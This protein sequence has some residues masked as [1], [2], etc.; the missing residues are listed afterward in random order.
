MRTYYNICKMFG[1]LVNRH[2][3]ER[4]ARSRL[5]SN[6]SFPRNINASANQNTNN[7]RENQNKNFGSEGNFMN[8]SITKISEEYTSP[9]V[10][11]IDISSGSGL[12]WGYVGDGS[13]SYSVI[14]VTEMCIL[15]SF[16][17]LPRLTSYDAVTR[18]FAH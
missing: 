5:L 9:L 14:G 13:A 2:D 6:E 15:R 3:K 18:E 4:T 17:V 7:I 10:N 1:H 11:M 16:L 12:V 8:Y